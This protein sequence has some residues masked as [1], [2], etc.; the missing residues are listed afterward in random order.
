MLLT[1]DWMP[2]QPVWLGKKKKK[3]VYGFMVKKNNKGS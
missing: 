3:L 2:S 1:W